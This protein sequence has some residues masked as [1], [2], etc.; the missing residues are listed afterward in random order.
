MKLLINL[1]TQLILNEQNKAKQCKAV[2][3]KINK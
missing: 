2:K 3:K 1:I